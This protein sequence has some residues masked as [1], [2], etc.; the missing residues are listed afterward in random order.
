MTQTTE[1]PD[2]LEQFLAEHPDTACP[3]CNYRLHR[4]T[5]SACPE[6]GTELALTVGRQRTVL[7]W[8]LL[9]SVSLWV[10]CG[11]ALYH[12][13]WLMISL[14][15]WDFQDWMPADWL[16]TA[17]LLPMLPLA[18]VTLLIRTWYVGLPR[19]VQLA[20]ALVVSIPVMLAL[21]ALYS[22]YN[23]MY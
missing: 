16:F 21:L 6:C 1:T 20:V 9:L 19:D 3:A 12:L 8:W 11:E 7:R 4:L 17:L 13:C 5:S 10:G 14:L 23:F 15:R 2:L 18:V 22:Y